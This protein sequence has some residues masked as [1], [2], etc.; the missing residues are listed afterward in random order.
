MKF[1]FSNLGS[2]YRPSGLPPADASA[3]TTTRMALGGAGDAH[4]HGPYN[5]KRIKKA[6]SRSSAPHW[7]PALS[8]IS[9]DGVVTV[10]ETDERKA[11]SE[12]KLSS[13]SK[14]AAKTRCFRSKDAYEYD[15]RKSSMP[16][17]LPAFSPT[18]F[19]F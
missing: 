13:K 6:T 9:E 3:T 2:C 17:I 12:K 5:S 11:Q 10:F 1:F 15:S 19:M 14:S 8:V 16:M 4:L 18:P 7:R